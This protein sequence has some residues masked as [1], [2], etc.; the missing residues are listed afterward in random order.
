MH[1]GSDSEG[2]T[3]LTMA[4]SHGQIQVVDHMIREHGQDP[5]GKPNIISFKR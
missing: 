5:K 4:A 2:R 3:P 1:S